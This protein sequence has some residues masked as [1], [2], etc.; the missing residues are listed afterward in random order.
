MNCNDCRLAS[1]GDG[2]EGRCMWRMPK[3]SLPT[4]YFYPG[5]SGHSNTPPPSGGSIRKDMPFNHC[6]CWREKL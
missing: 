3:I 1:W 5:R 6:P 4:A 2:N